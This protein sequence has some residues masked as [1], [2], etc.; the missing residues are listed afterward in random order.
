MS[1][2]PGEIC[3]GGSCQLSCPTGQVVCGG[4]CA[5]AS[6]LSCGTRI[7]LGTLGAG[8]STGTD[9]RRLP[10]A[11]QEEWFLIRFPES[12][13]F[14]RHGA[15][16]PRVR[17]A[18]NEGGVFRF[19]VRTSCSSGNG[20]CGSGGT[21]GSRTDWTFEDTCSSGGTGCSTRRTG[22][23]NT[24]LIRVRRTNS[25]S[26]CARYSLSISR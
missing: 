17:F 3:S 25:G 9:L 11:G 24:T 12:A 13:T 22:W 6:A 2:G 21:A 26:S 4:E 8:S 16:R 19:D 18:T 7:D 14:R 5:G 23:P 1:C 10:I 15:G 20:P